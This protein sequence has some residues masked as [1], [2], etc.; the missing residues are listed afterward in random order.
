MQPVIIVAADAMFPVLSGQRDAPSI[1]YYILGYFHVAFPDS[2]FSGHKNC[3]ATLLFKYLHPLH[4][5]GICQG[6]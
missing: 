3:Y 2:I 6:L 5:A 4:C 1:K